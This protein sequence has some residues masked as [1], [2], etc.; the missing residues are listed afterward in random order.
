[1]ADLSSHRTPN[2]LVLGTEK[3]GRAQVSEGRVAGRNGSFKGALPS[4]PLT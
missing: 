2:I 1:M 4:T 3:E